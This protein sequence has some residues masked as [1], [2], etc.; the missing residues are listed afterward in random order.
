MWLILYLTL[1]SI[2]VCPILSPE[3]WMEE[4][5]PEDHPQGRF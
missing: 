5:Y 1:S 4:M 2:Q 3:V